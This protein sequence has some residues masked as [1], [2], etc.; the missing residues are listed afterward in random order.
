MTLAITNNPDQYGYTN[1]KNIFYGKEN[2]TCSLVN[3][4]KWRLNTQ[5]KD[6]N[7]LYDWIS[8]YGVPMF[9]W[10]G[11]LQ[12][13]ELFKQLLRTMIDGYVSQYA[14][15]EIIAR[16]LLEFINRLY[17]KAVEVMEITEK[18]LTPLDDFDDLYGK[19]IDLQKL[20]DLKEK[21]GDIFGIY[22]G[23]CNQVWQWKESIF[24]KKT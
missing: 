13:P 23:I 11:V 22:Q 10:S 24:L 16:K 20:L 7:E 2:N 21:K 1:W 15:K 17:K 14:S 9:L 8:L 12:A 19:K 5:D 6:E 18:D 3:D 4:E